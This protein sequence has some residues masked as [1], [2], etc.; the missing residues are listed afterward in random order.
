MISRLPSLVDEASLLV[1]LFSL[2]ILPPHQSYYRQNFKSMVRFLKSR[3][4][5]SVGVPLAPMASLC[6]NPKSMQNKPLLNKME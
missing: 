4:S 2:S 6:S 3:S 1:S 5:E